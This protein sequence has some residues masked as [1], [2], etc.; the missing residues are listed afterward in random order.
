MKMATMIRR[1]SIQIARF[2]APCAVLVL[3][4]LMG[5]GDDHRD[6]VLRQIKEAEALD[7]TATVPSV[8]TPARGTPPSPDLS[9]SHGLGYSFLGGSTVRLGMD[10]TAALAVLPREG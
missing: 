2:A 6:K 4:A 3:V 5:C 10:K 9:S 8:S 7:K 1:R